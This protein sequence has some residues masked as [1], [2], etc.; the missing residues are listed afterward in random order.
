[1]KVLRAETAMK[2]QARQRANNI[3]NSNFDV[4]PGFNV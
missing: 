2:N 4:H 1:V 3:I